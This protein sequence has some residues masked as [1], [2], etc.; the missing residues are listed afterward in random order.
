MEDVS[1]G[2]DPLVSSQPPPSSSDLAASGD[3]GGDRGRR[4][5]AIS[6]ATAA[7]VQRTGQAGGGGSGGSGGGGGFGGGGGSGVGGRG[8]EAAAGSRGP[9][10]RLG[11]PGGKKAH[12][13]TVRDGDW[14]CGTCSKLNY[15]EDDACAV[16]KR[17]KPLPPRLKSPENNPPP[18]PGNEAQAGGKGRAFTE[19][20]RKK[21]KEMEKVASDYRTFMATKLRLD[22]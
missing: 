1:A 11:G 2:R 16:C 3:R 21:N 4:P 12:W 17:P 20:Q 6:A 10:Q 9:L 8:A 18:N 13:C 14:P 22:K 15:E 5:A 19:E 7:G